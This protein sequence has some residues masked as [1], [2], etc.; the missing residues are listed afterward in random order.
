MLVMAE[1]VAAIFT[2]RSLWDGISMLGK[3]CGTA[4]SR[5]HRVGICDPRKIPVAV[6]ICHASQVLN[7]ASRIIPALEF[8]AASAL[9]TR[10]GDDKSQID[11]QIG[12]D[13]FSSRGNVPDVR[14]K[15]CTVYSKAQ[16]HHQCK[17]GGGACFNG[18]DARNH[19]KG[20][21]SRQRWQDN[22]YPLTKG[23]LRFHQVFEI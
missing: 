12:K 1:A 16:I 13:R 6:P 5:D 10:D 17:K 11:G 20:Q 14:S 21:H 4:Q 15:C 7:A 3:I 18:G 2:A 23:M 9:K 8:R 19:H 22:L